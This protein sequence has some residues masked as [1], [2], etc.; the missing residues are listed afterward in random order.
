MCNDW[1]IYDNMYREK[2]MNLRVGD[3]WQIE[4]RVGRRERVEMRRKGEK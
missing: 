3:D 4:T 1:K 2:V